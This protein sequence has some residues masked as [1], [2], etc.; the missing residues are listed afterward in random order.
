MNNTRP[1]LND[2]LSAAM[3]NLKAIESRTD[4]ASKPLAKIQAAIETW[5]DIPGR[6]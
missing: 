5:P 4:E 3:A 6:I 2:N 1:K